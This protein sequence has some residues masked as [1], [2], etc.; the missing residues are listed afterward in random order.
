VKWGK[1]IAGIEDGD[2]VTVMFKDRTS[3]TANL[4]LGC[5]G[6]DSALR[7]LYVAPEAVPQYSGISRISAF[8]S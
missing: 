3:D 6:I 2:G 5:D 7:T 8:L 1:R 4:V